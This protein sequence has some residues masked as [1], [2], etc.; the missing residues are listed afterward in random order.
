MIPNQWYI[1]L[2]SSQVKYKPVGATRMGEKLVFWRHPSGKVSC[3]PDRCPHRGVALSQGK[4]LGNGNLQCPFH[5]FEFD[6]SGRVTA[7]PA[8]GRQAP[9]PKIFKLQG[10]PTHEAQGIIWIWWGS[11]PP[12]NLAPPPFFDD[13]DERFSYGQVIDPWDTHYSRVIEN[14]LDV[15]H[16]PYVHHNTIGRGGRT[17]VDGPLVRWLDE[18]RFN[19]YVFNRR[20]EGEPPRKASQLSPEGSPVFL[21]FVFPNLWQ[22]HISP[23]TRIVAA[24]VPVDED[25]TL[26]YLRFYQSFMRLPVLRNLVNWL[27]MP[28][29]LFIARQDRRVVRTHEP[30]ASGLDIG[31]KLVPGDGPIIEYRRKRQRLM[32]AVGGKDTSR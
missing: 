29:N 28:A 1:V 5:G 30:Q 2:D 32:E 26:L 8:N 3:L 15:M 27:S 25:H 24:F 17:L 6:S 4:V 7:I 31:E 18:E 20:D 11:S 19:V 21:Q 13:L 23:E 12:D 9:V 14:Q 16:L 22:N 10:Y